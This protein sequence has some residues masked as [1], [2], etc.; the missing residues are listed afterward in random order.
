MGHNPES[1]TASEQPGR[2]ER[3]KD[4]VLELGGLV[5]DGIFDL[6]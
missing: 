5:L 4:A 3:Y 2:F 1:Q 6:F